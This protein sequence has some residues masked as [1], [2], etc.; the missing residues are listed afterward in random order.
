MKATY[1]VNTTDRTYC[2]TSLTSARRVAKSW[3]NA[4]I[5]AISEVN[6]LVVVTKTN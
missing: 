5:Y 6:G 2:T 1:E 4:T 3:R